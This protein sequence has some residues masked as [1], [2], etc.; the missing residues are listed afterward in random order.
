[1]QRNAYMVDHS[2]L[3]IAVYDGMAGGTK[4]TVDYAAA[5]SVRIITLDPREG[6]N[7]GFLH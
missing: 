3:V 1:M 6:L 2:S 7:A 5:R 4:N